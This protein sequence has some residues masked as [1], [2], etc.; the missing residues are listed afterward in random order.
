[1]VQD[2]REG[3]VSCDAC[4]WRQADIFKPLSPPDVIALNGYKKDHIRVPAGRTLIRRDAKQSTFFTLF[5]G[6]A[7][8]YA[9]INGGR[10]IFNFCLPGDL[11]GVQIPLTG[12][13]PYTVQTLTDA[14][15]CAFES[16]DVEGMFER[17]PRLGME[18]AR[19]AASEAALMEI[20]LST[21]GR[22]SAES[23]VAYLLAELYTRLRQRKL[24]TDNT[25]VLP[26]TQEHLADALGLSTVHVSRMLRVLSDDGLARLD[27]GHL[28]ILDLTG[29]THRA[30]IDG[31]LD[32]PQPALL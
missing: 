21:V 8:R 14:S 4:P 17:H 18:M 15:L 10:Q 5:Q 16:D 30:E 27:R 20:H 1:M 7:Y 28:T 23:R 3:Y 26:L 25:C 22:R 11:I 32:F 31:E 19:L 24:T 12:R 2:K 9:T 6:W 29:L 13:V